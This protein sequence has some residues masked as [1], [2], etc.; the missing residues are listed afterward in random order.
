MDTVKLNISPPPVA[1]QV[2]KQTESAQSTTQIQENSQ[3]RST[4]G[5][6]ITPVIQFDSE[7]LSVIFRVRDGLSGEVKQEYPQESVI[8]G[9]QA[10]AEA[11]AKQAETKPNSGTSEIQDIAVPT[12][13]A[14][15]NGGVQ[16][17]LVSTE[18]ETTQSN[19]NAA[20]VA[21]STTGV[22]KGLGNI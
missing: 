13:D 8:R 6:F 10:V 14:G 21:T 7:T 18:A 9:R 5:L 4:A 2:S 22:A 3:K 17:N 16:V 15:S 1:E 11:T 12:A 20:G 19:G